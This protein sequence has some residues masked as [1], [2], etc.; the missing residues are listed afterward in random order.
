MAKNISKVIINASSNKVWD[1]LVKPELVKQWQYGGKLLTDWK[2]GNEIRFVNEWEGNVYEQ[3]GKVLEFSPYTLIKYSLFAPRPG[4]EDKP[5]NYFIMSYILN[6][7]GDSTE[8]IIKQDD[9]RPKTSNQESYEE[10]D[11]SIL[12]GLK[13]LVEAQ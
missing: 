9:N 7:N 6:D 10:D 13:K 2:V 4:L 1:A 8:L 12:L 11:N 3:W 5:E